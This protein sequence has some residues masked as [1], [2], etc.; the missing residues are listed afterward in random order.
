M[1]LLLNAL[2]ASMLFIPIAFAE[3]C[4]SGCDKDKKKEEGT[5]LAGSC[6]KDGDCDKEEKKEEGTLA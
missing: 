6:G 4:D 3:D 2:M 5:F 1:K